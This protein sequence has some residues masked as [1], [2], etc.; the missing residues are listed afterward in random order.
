MAGNS[1]PATA[2][3]TRIKTYQE[4]LA[5]EQAEAEAKAK[6]EQEAQEAQEAQ[7]KAEREAKEKGERETKEQREREAREEVEKANKIPSAMCL[8]TAD[9]SSGPDADSGDNQGA[10]GAW[11]RRRVA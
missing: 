1:I 4:V 3:A 5:R 10:H 6:Q 2:T 9:H 7:E 11:Q 8:C